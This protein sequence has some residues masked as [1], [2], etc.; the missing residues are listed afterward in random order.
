MKAIEAILVKL[1]ERERRTLGE[2][3]ERQRLAR[4]LLSCGTGARQG[5]L[6]EAMT[7]A[8][9]HLAEA[10]RAAEEPA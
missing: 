3:L 4:N 9:N 2:I 6:R 10:Q 8:R 7:R 5:E 1:D